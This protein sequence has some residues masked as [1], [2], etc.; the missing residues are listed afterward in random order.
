M[1]KILVFSLLFPLLITAFAGTHAKTGDLQ[2]IQNN[3]QWQQQIEFAADVYGG[4]LFLE[5]N[6]FTWSFSNTAE[7]GDFKHRG[8]LEELSNF[9]MKYHAFKT[10]FIGAN[11]NVE[12]SGE[13]RFSNYY[14]YFLGNDQSAWHSGVSAFDA[15]RY[16]QLY[17]GI[18]MLVHSQSNSMKYDL[19]VA[20]HAA[21][22]QIK[23][24]YNGLDNIRIID[25]NLELVTSI[26]TIVELK[27][28]AY[29]WINASKI[30]VSC[31]FRLDD[32]ELSFYFPEGYDENYELVIDPATLIF[33]SYSGATSD[34]WGYSAT[35]DNAGNLYGAGIAFANGYPTTVG[36]YQTSFAGGVGL[37]VAD[38]TISKFTADGTSLIYSTYL[39][40][41]NE[42]LPYSLI[43]D[44]ENNLIVYGATGSDNFPVTGASY[45]DSFNGGTAVL[46]D[47]VLSFTSGS[48]GFVSKFNADGT[49]LIG[50][51]FIGGTSND[52]LND[53]TATA[54]NYGD[55]ARG[56][57]NVDILGNIYIASCTKSSNLPVSPDVFQTTFGGNQDGFIAKFNPD[58]SDLVWCS[59]I[60]G[61]AADGAYSIKKMNG[62]KFIVCGGTASNNFPTTPGALNEDYLGGTADGFATVIESNASAILHS[63][64]IGTNSYDQTFLTEI[65]DFN[66]IFVTGQTRGAYPVVGDVYN[67]PGSSQYITKLDS[68]LSVI[69]FSTVFGSGT[70]SVN[71][72]PTAFLVDNC[73]HIY[74]AGWGG[75]V[76]TSFNFE[77]GNVHDMPVSD[78]AFQPTTDGSD[79]YLIVLEKDADSLIYATYFGGPVSDEH[80]DGG[81]SRFDKQGVV[82]E[83]VC[84]GCGGSDDFPTSEGVVS[85]TNNAPNCNLGVFKFQ[86]AP[87]ITTAVIDAE[88]LNGCIPLTVDFENNSINAAGIEWNFGTGETSTD[89]AP[90]Y[91]YDTPGAYDVTLVAVVADVCGV[92]DTDHITIEAYGFPTADFDFL[93]DPG[94]I[95]VATDFTDMSTD[96]AT[97]E[98]DF[99]DGGSSTEQNPVHQYLVAGSYE[100]CL[101]VETEHGCESKICDTIDILEISLLDVPNAFSPNGDGVND[102]FFPV[103]YGLANFEFRIYNRWGELLFLTNDP[104]KGWNGVYKGEEQELDVYVYV[105]SG[106][107]LD[108]VPYYRQGNFTLVR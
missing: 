14:N 33:A 6:S 22:S 2:Y 104:E 39:G 96:A 30:N 99:G 103:N 97:W 62:E 101:T 56:E 45:D 88:P 80:V 18:D 93:P 21:Q 41:T 69:Q 3:G 19:I 48:D 108:G 5:K 100:V 31:E 76:N 13:D 94:S 66:S 50:S 47:Y 23:I 57:V 52:A 67:N 64:Y 28:V 32:N 29:Q 37:Y 15:V 89:D 65:D 60:G 75:A 49:D 35:Y 71:I 102:I 46:V 1:K 34:N 43:V 26:A 91:T 59:Y 63:S 38:I 55:H 36:S 83:A 11:T 7:L 54:Y 40:G 10:N 92:N 70:T 27:P 20:P 68:T 105:I 87:P 4:R 95:F 81:T 25:G 9:I 107:G 77:T 17:P 98:W 73:Q 79:F 12:L 53:A 90:T 82:Y 74:V 44:A 51:S 58:L 61:S 106:N 8:N 42:D 86:L 85:N 16:R 24:R 78:D 72:S 84:A